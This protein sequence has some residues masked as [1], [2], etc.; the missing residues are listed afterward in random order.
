[1]NAR[2]L[3]CTRAPNSEALLCKGKIRGLPGLGNLA[4]SLAQPD[5]QNGFPSSSVSCR[6]AHTMQAISHCNIIW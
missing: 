2:I 6:L 3:A 1:M 4:Q 5:I